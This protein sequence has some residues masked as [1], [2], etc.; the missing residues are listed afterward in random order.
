MFDISTC[1]W[2]EMKAITYKFYRDKR[3]V[4]DTGYYKLLL[5]YHVLAQTPSFSCRNDKK[6]K[7]FQTF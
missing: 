6:I 5:T 4:L 2:L 3:Y 7:L 1:T